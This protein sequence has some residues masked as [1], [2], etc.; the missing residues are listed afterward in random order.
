MFEFVLDLG[1]L[2]IAI[3]IGQPT[4]TA[5][6]VVEIGAYTEHAQ[7]DDGHISLRA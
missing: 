3:T 6:E 5:A 7:D 1:P 4:E 2:H